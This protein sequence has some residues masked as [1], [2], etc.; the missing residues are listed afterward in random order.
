MKVGPRWLSLLV[1]AAALLLHG[2]I[3]YAIQG[4]DFPAFYWAGWCARTGNSELLYNR[5]AQQDFFTHLVKEPNRVLTFVYHPAIAYLFLPFSYLPFPA[6]LRLWMVLQLGVIAWATYA[7]LRSN[8]TDQVHGLL[9]IMT[10]VLVSA[11]VLHNQALGQ[12]TS[13]LMGLCALMLALDF[14]K[15]AGLVGALWCVTVLTKPI[16]GTLLLLWWRRGRVL[17]WVAA[18]A[19]VVTVLVSGPRLAGYISTFRATTM[20]NIRSETHNPSLLK[21]TTKL[22]QHGVSIYMILSGAILLVTAILALRFRSEKE[23]ILLALAASGVVSPVLELHHLMIGLLPFVVLFQSVLNNEEDQ[24][25]QALT[26][27]ALTTLVLPFPALRSSLGRYLPLVGSACIW[28]SWVLKAHR[29]ARV[30]A[31][32]ALGGRDFGAPQTS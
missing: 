16:T 9:P 20:A 14:R 26:F 17:L 1:L 22:T 12:T 18:V 27:I 23:R 8:S 13:L 31:A 29:C 21:V 24:P 4:G 30:S 10:L 5:V 15:Y 19:L 25:V 6:A 3:I 32:V 7:V 11:P 28:A 2:T